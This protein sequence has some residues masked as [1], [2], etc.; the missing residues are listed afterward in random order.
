MVRPRL[1]HH[2]RQPLARQHLHRLGIQQ[3]EHPLGDGWSAR[4]QDLAH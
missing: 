1:L 3:A 2:P 4:A